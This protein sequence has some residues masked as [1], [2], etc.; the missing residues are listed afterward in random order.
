[1]GVDQTSLGG[2]EM[3]ERVLVESPFLSEGV[4]LGAIH[5]VFN[6]LQLQSPPGI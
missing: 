3:V 2:A 5:A 6:D 4:L 1:M